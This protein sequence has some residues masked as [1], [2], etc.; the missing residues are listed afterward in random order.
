M[1]TL[2]TSDIECHILLFAMIK[3]LK[4]CLQRLSEDNKIRR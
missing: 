2:A 4:N 3:I 1:S